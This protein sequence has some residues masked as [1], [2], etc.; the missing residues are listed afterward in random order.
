M[1]KCIMAS[2]V[3]TNARLK[4]LSEMHKL[5]SRVLDSDSIFFTQKSGDYT[6]DLGDFLGEFTNELDPSEGNYISEFF[7]AGP[8]NYY[9]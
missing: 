2:F 7:S 8:K 3:T 5:N 1:M 9:F 6:P 4:L